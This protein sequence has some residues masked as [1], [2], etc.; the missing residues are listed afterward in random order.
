MIVE[1]DRGVLD[2]IAIDAGGDPGDSFKMSVEMT[3]I[4]ESDPIGRIRQVMTL[5]DQL[6]RS[7]NTDLG[8]ISMRGK[9]RFRLENP[10]QMEWT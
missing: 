5:T 4:S 9:A 1:S 3:L 10:N 7:A 6:F 8:E 2:E